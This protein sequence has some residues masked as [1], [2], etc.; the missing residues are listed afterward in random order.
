MIISS[1]PRRGGA[2]WGIGLAVIGLGFLAFTF[3]RSDL[4]ITSA[5]LF[6]AGPL[7]LFGA[8]IAFPA[9]RPTQSQV[10]NPLTLMILSVS[11][12]ILIVPVL[13]VFFGY[14]QAVL[15]NIPAVPYINVAQGIYIVA[16]V[17]CLIGFV[18]AY[19]APSGERRW[20][21][22]NWVMEPLAL[23]AFAAAAAYSFFSL[24][25]ASNDG[26]GPASALG[27]ALLM[28]RSLAPLCIVYIIFKR[29]RYVAE[30]RFPLWLFTIGLLL[31]ISASISA[32]RANLVYAS[33]AF[34][35]MYSLYNS[36]LRFWQVIVSGVIALAVVF[37]LGQVRERVILGDYVYRMRQHYQMSRMDNAVENAQ[38]YFNGPQF[39]GYALRGLE[40]KNRT[41]VASLLESTPVIGQQF[42]TSSGSYW[43]NFAIYN[44]F[45]SQDQVYPAQ[46]EIYNNYG[47]VGLIAFYMMVGALIANL[48]RVFL[49]CRNNPF[50]AYTTAY[51]TL[52]ICASINLSLSVLGQFMIYN[53]APLLVFWV[54]ANILTRR[55][56]RLHK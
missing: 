40:Q 22:P 44:H 6:M 55:L 5:L 47:W 2:S 17:A 15:P 35:T 11:F 7:L 32:N 34:S 54:A 26:T 56:A 18:W 41:A 46:V 51:L 36:R 4:D 33:L 23:V 16:M 28:L 3:F 38:V 9:L 12:K 43:Y 45:R 49:G 20:V 8:L 50:L 13:I 14:S 27:F 37:S 21:T 1:K 39:A 31:V 10:L 24:R 42:R 29:Q 25:Q 19:R 53:A 30:Q 48:H 52:L